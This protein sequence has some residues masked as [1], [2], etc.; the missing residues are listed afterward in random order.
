MKDRYVSIMAC[1][2]IVIIEAI[3]MSH[4]MN[5]HLMALSFAVLGGIAGFNIRRVKL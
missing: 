1:I 5:G 4:G 3:A 2:S